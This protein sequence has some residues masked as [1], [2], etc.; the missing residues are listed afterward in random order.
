MGLRS[1]RVWSTI[2]PPMGGVLVRYPEGKMEDSYRNKSSM[3]KLRNIRRR[4]SIENERKR[5]A[6]I[7]REGREIETRRRAVAAKK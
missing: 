6:G 3:E 2:A 7:V 4:K 1:P 5:R